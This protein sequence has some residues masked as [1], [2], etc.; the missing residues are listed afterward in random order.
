M[1]NGKLHTILQQ[2]HHTFLS[3]NKKCLSLRAI[4]EKLVQGERNLNMFEISETQ[5]NLSI[6]LFF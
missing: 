6:Q 4:F 5:P 2:K 3:L 1:Q